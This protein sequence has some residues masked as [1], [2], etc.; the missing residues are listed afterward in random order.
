MNKRTLHRPYEQ[1][2]RLQYTQGLMFNN[3][4]LVEMEER[5]LAEE[6]YIHSLNQQNDEQITG[7]VDKAIFDPIAIQQQQL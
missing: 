6:I 3:E 5:L 4:D 7:Q 1:K 2:K